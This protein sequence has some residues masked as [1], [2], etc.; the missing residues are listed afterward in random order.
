MFDN[1]SANE[2]VDADFTWSRAVIDPDEYLHDYDDEA[3][4]TLASALRQLR[5]SA[6][7]ERYNDGMAPS[8]PKKRREDGDEDANARKLVG[9]LLIRWD[10]FLDYFGKQFDT[11]KTSLVGLLIARGGSAALPL[12]DTL[13]LS[14]FKLQPNVEGSNPLL[15]TIVDHFFRRCWIE[16]QLELPNAKAIDALRCV[17]LWLAKKTGDN[18]Q[19]TWEPLY[20]FIFGLSSFYY[21]NHVSWLNS[22]LSV[23]YY[24]LPR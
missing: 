21:F 20:V 1:C 9:N 12:A 18:L 11:M 16:K 22:K 17:L 14:G 2:L 10:S 24:L 8:K 3:D 4:A 23:D 5:T 6:A 15:L 19:F 13:L 7:H